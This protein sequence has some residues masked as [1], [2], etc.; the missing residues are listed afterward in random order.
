MPPKARRDQLN[1]RE[2][3]FIENGKTQPRC[4]CVCGLPTQ[5]DLALDPPTPAPGRLSQRLELASMNVEFGCYTE[6]QEKQKMH[7]R[8]E[9]GFSWFSRD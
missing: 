2:T 3:G 4:A 9:H 5:T 1:G 8:G 6:D 7:I